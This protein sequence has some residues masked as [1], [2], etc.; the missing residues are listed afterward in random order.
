MP[1]STQMRTACSIRTATLADLD[2]I[3]EVCLGAAPFDDSVRYVN[4]YR[5]QFPEDDIKY[6][7]LWLQYVINPIHDD[8]NVMVAEAPSLEDSHTMKIG[9]YAVWNVSYRKKRKHGSEYQPQDRMSFSPLSS[10]LQI[11]MPC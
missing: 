6:C 8:F 5:E 10:P 7:K 11:P 3:L 9:G 1:H 4:L 2:G